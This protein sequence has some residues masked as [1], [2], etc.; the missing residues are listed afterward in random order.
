MFRLIQPR[1]IDYYVDG[2]GREPF[3]E[4]LD[5]LK[6]IST[7]ARIKLRLDRLKLGNFGNCRSVG[8]GVFELKIDFG[9]GYRVYFGLAHVVL[10]LCGGDKGSQES[11]IQQAKRYWMDYRSR[12]H[13]HQT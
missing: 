11:D 6:D 13:A 7:R 5:A 3:R 4:W 1:V 9:P 10:V 2:R 8:G 12:Q